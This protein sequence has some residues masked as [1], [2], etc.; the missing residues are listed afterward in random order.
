M[1]IIKI[2]IGSFVFS[3]FLP[4]FPFLFLYGEVSMFEQMP[5]LHKRIL[6]IV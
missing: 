2:T 5:N 3:P 1:I 4:L 6:S